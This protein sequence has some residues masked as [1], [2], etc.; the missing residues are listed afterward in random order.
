[1]GRPGIATKR[2]Y[3]G[4]PGC[5]ACQARR[6]SPFLQSHWISIDYG[7]GRS[8]AAA[9]LHVCAYI[10]LHRDAPINTIVTHRLCTHRLHNSKMARNATGQI[11]REIDS[12]EVTLALQVF[13]AGV[14]ASKIARSSAT[15]W[16][17]VDPKIE[18]ITAALDRGKVVLNINFELWIGD[19]AQIRAKRV[20]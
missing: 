9:H 10:V 20:R 15:T 3:N 2:A 4:R 19:A 1:M 12:R 6:R 7:F 14:S 13:A 16:N 5:A 11:E 8:S 17:G 18:V